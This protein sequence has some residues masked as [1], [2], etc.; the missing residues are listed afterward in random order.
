MTLEVCDEGC[1]DCD[2]IVIQ[3]CGC[4]KFQELK[5]KDQRFNQ[6]LLISCVS[7]TNPFRLYFNNYSSHAL[8]HPLIHCIHY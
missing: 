4:D 5:K 8:L 6:Q 1:Y 7:L 3:F 2:K